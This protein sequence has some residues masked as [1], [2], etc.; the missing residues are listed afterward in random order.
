VISDSVFVIRIM[1]DDYK[2]LDIWQ[3]SRLLVSMV[4]KASNKLP[5]S[6]IFG[7][8]SQINRAV[9][10]VPSNIAESFGR[11]TKKEKIQFLH[12]AKGS[13]YE[14]ETQLILCFDQSF[15]LKDDLKL[16]LKE[17][18]GTKKLIAGFIRY[19]SR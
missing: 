10:S 11:N 7:L 12:I 3:K 6:E 5:K 18:D 19:L 8:K 9:V 15:I 14:V 4:Y 1:K 2:N 17:I 13:L 16:I